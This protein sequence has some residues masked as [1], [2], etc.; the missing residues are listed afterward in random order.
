MVARKPRADG[1]RRGAEDATR[2]SPTSCRGPRGPRLARSDHRRN[3]AGCRDRVGSSAADTL[4]PSPGHD[5]L[6]EWQMLVKPTAGGGSSDARPRYAVRPHGGGPP[7]RGRARTA[8]IARPTDPGRP[9]DP[10]R[11]AASGR[12]SSSQARAD[13]PDYF[14]PLVLSVPVLSG[15]RPDR[16]AAHRRD[17]QMA[18]ARR[19]ASNANRPARCAAIVDA[20]A[21]AGLRRRSSCSAA[22]GEVTEGTF[23]EPVSSRGSH[24]GATRG[25]LRRRQRP[26]TPRRLHH[27]VRQPPSPGRRAGPEDVRNDHHLVFDRGLPAQ[28]LG[29]LEILASSARSRGGRGRRWRCTCRGWRSA[30][31]PG[32]TPVRSGS[33]TAI[34]TAA[35]PALPRAVRARL[36]RRALGAQADPRLGAVR[37]RGS[38][39]AQQLGIRRG[40]VDRPGSCPAGGARPVE[41]LVANGSIA[42]AS[43]GR[44][45]GRRDRTGMR[46]HAS[47]GR[48]AAQLRPADLLRPNL[49]PRLLR[50]RANA[51][52]RAP[53]GAVCD[54]CGGSS[55]RSPPFG[56]YRRDHDQP[57][58]C[59]PSPAPSG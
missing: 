15:R 10:S 21:L 25:L 33:S 28:R 54:L 20:L 44:R 35:C 39:R 22:G 41:V 55:C 7:A 5:L 45:S 12:S 38:R 52:P 14:Q 27:P 59:W 40:R 4:Y 48:R 43:G 53:L 47:A 50:T 51:L 11:T 34:T 1:G 8:A 37:P 2:R 9:A 36:A 56:S 3:A 18:P 16:R 19:E 46:D 29:M 57:P 6:P 58:R 32:T 17:H 31:F 23:D 26:D 30:C 24:P 42:G 49:P 13:L